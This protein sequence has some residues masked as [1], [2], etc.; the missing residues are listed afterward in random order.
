MRVKLS[1]KS[2]D[3]GI[4]NMKSKLRHQIRHQIS[5]VLTVAVMMTMVPMNGL[6]VETDGNGRIGAGCATVSDLPVPEQKNSSADDENSEVDADSELIDDMDLATPDDAVT[7]SQEA[8]SFIAIVEKLDKEK[9]LQ[10]VEN[11]ADASKIY[12]ITLEEALLEVYDETAIYR[13]YEQIPDEEKEF[14]KVVLAYEK[15]EEIRVAL[16]EAI[17]EQQD[18]RAM[19]AEKQEVCFWL[20]SEGK[21]FN[22]RTFFVME[23]EDPSAYGTLTEQGI[24]MREGK[25]C[26]YLKY[27]LR[28][29]VKYT[30]ICRPYDYRWVEGEVLGG[31]SEV[32]VPLE[33]LPYCTVQFEVKQENGDP[34]T[35]AVITVINT[36]NPRFGIPPADE[37]G[38]TFYVPVQSQYPE[39]IDANSISYSVQIPGQTS[40]SGVYKFTISDEQKTIVIPISMTGKKT[41][42]EIYDREWDYTADELEIGTIEELAAYSYWSNEIYN[43]FENKRIVLTDDIDITEIQWYPIGNNTSA[44]AIGSFDGQGHTIMMN[45]TQMSQL[46]YNSRG[47][48]FGFITNSTI[49]NL[50]VEG[51]IRVSGFENGAKVGGLAALSGSRTIIKNC[52]SSVDIEFAD[53]PDDSYIGGLVGW[54]M[55]SRLE[56]CSYD[57][58]INIRGS[59]AVY[60]GG[61]TGSMSVH[62]NMQHVA[63]SGS[64]SVEGTNPYCGGI[65]GFMTAN[66]DITGC[67]SNMDLIA[68][69]ETV[70]GIVGYNEWGSVS[71]AYFN[72]T[73]T[74]RDDVGQP[75]FGKKSVHATFESCGYAEGS[76]HNDNDIDGVTCIIAG[77]D[78]EEVLNILNTEGK[79]PWFTYVDGEPVLII[80]QISSDGYQGGWT[81]NPVRFELSGGL[82]DHLLGYEYL[83]SEASEKPGIADSRWSLCE[84]SQRNTVTA[85]HEGE[86][87]YWFRTKDQAG[88]IEGPVYVQLDLTAPILDQPL[89]TKYEP[90]KDQVTVR[91]SA[92][93]SISGVKEIRYLITKSGE[94]APSIEQLQSGL[95]Y[96][97]DEVVITGLPVGSQSV[98]YGIATD[99]AGNYSEIEYVEIGIE[100][101]GGGNPV[102]REDT[103]DHDSGDTGS[104]IGANGGS[105]YIKPNGSRCSSE[106]FLIDGT[107][108]YFDQAGRMVTGWCFDPVYQAWFYLDQNGSMAV[109]WIK[110]PDGKWYYLNP[111]SDGRRGAMY[112]DTWIDGYYLGDDGAWDGADAIVHADSVYKK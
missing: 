27:E 82:S 30:Y 45:V 109:G 46:G 72:G 83:C 50:N 87:Y 15:L 40:V 90:D 1:D 65:T 108:Y 52:T 3:R 68:D 37:D 53:T 43:V 103:S 29:D 25:P 105:G 34:A 77:M 22:D 64:I 74:T 9:L 63:S 76:G 92:S 79:L 56:N 96:Q 12:D 31:T 28:K 41:V 8:I 17:R 13:L 99:L 11:Y 84:G 75:A 19:D 73:C 85:S 62:S 57:G 48:L 38:T 49:E 7:M 4:M 71:N 110:L 14:G 104:W 91:M 98:V 55:L 58:D 60:I 95:L 93:D 47:G 89:V 86:F 18:I 42:D 51:D 100:E 5:I 39:I 94:A 111:V 10:L 32:S 21:N 67:S 102:H 107:W 20:D 69:G 6:A 16:Q 106:W 78:P 36:G 81:K 101:E 23:K 24:G 66:T 97:T 2:E 54:M 88:A 61:M 35:G 112:A 70:G 26:Q 44:S 33:R 80:I 59:D